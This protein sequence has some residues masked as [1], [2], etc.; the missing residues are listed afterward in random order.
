MSWNE[1]ISWNIKEDLINVK[2]DTDNSGL[3]DL[4]DKKYKKFIEKTYQVIKD[5]K[6]VGLPKI[7]EQIKLITFRPF[8]AIHFVKYIAE[9]EEIEHLILVVYSINHEAAILIDEMIKQKKIKKCTILMSNLRN[10]AHRQKEQ[11]TRDLFV[12]NKNVELLFCSSHAKITAIK[13]KQNSY[14]IDG[15]GNLSYNSRVENYTIDND[16]NYFNF[17]KKWIEEIKEYLKGKK[18][19]ILT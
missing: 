5:V 6:E 18:E 2:K 7:N 9:Q 1:N 14:V 12:E 17:T 19:L 4:K 15:S 10:K 11:L 16:V 13:T 3:E 8:N